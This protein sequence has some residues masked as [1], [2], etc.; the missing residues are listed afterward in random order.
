MRNRIISFLKSH[1]TCV[2]MFWGCARLFMYIW[3][4]FVPLQEKTI[5]FCS[6]GGRKFD[7][8][9]KAI[10][11]EICSKSEFDE[12]RLIWAFVDPEKYSLPRGEKVKVDTVS[13]FHAL[14]YSRVWVSNSGM[15]RGI[16]FSGKQG[17]PKSY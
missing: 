7:D 6:F 3:G 9:P 5:I 10:Y 12:W 14:L 13:F 1:P 16:E 2:R 8:S 17:I 15:D 11:D 4:A